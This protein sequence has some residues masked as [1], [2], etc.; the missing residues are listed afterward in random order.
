MPPTPAPLHPKPL[1]AVLLA[2]A[3]AGCSNAASTK[4]PSPQP[5]PDPAPTASA[6]TPPRRAILLAPPGSD[7]AL[8]GS[9]Q[10]AL[11]ALASQSGLDHETVSALTPDDLGTANDIVLVLPPDPGVAALASSALNAQFAAIGVEGASPAANLS[12]IGA[13]G[14]RPDQ[15]GFIA[16]FLAAVITPDYRV[17]VISPADTATGLAATQGFMNGAKYY[18]GRCVP[19]YPPFHVYPVSGEAATGSGDDVGAAFD[20]LVGLGVTTIYLGPGVSPQALPPNAADRGVVLLGAAPTGSAAWAA[21]V[22]SSPEQALQALWPDLVQ[23]H[24]GKTL[25]LPITIVDVDPAAVS[26]GRLR[27]A[28]QVLTELASGLIDTRVDPSTGQ[29][30]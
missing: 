28:N 22:R 25:P 4:I 15:E 11:Q 29:P 3:L 14:F 17:G 2:A 1:V 9:I 7:P 16:G 30:R 20:R 6:T 5:M 19:A 23:G 18:C 12:V 8:I 27:L 24:G 21:T 10:P 13:E 26:E